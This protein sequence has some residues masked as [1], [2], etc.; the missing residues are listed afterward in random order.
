MLEGVVTADWT[1]ST[2]LMN[3]ITSWTLSNSKKYA[4]TFTNDGAQLILA[5]TGSR[6]PGPWAFTRCFLFW[7]ILISL[8]PVHIWLWFLHI[9]RRH[10]LFCHPMYI[11][12]YCVASLRWVPDLCVALLMRALMN[13]RCSSSHQPPRDSATPYP[14]CD[15]ASFRSLTNM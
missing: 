15:S 2:L 4:Y 6:I 12:Y 11:L 14:R 8:L 9:Q 10:Y 3:L 5:C 1:A 7:R 13:S